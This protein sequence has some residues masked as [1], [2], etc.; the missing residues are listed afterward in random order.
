MQGLRPD[1][2]LA[3]LGQYRRNLWQGQSSRKRLSK[4]RGLAKN[5]SLP[6]RIGHLPPHRDGIMRQALL[7]GE[8]EVPLCG[9]RRRGR[10]PL[11]LYLRQPGTPSS[12]LFLRRSSRL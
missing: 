1:S 10:E 12:K 5:L 6:E 3:P 8:L 4:D 11:L 9:A 7:T 2:I